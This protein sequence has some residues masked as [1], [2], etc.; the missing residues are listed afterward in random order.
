MRSLWLVCFSLLLALAAA[1]S[2]AYTP[3][4]GTWWTPNEP[5]TGL[6]I[7]VQDN[8]LV[9]AAYVYDPIG[10][11]TWYTAT[12]FLTGNARFDGQ[13]DA[14]VGGQC[15]GC[16]W[17][18]N[19]ERLG[20]GGPIRI[21]FNLTDPTKA[22]LT[23][24]GRTRPI[25]RF[26]FYLKRP[27]DGSRSIQLTKMLGEWQLVLD[28]SEINSTFPYAGDVI[29]FESIDVSQSP[30]FF[31]GCRVDDSLSGF[32]STFALNN[33]DAAG[34]YDSSTQEH[35]IV[36]SDTST[37]YLMY[38]GRVG[39]DHFRGEVSSYRKG[40]NP[41]TFYPARGFRSASRSFVDEGIGPSKAADVDAAPRQGLSDLFDFDQANA[42]PAAKRISKIEP[43]RLD[44]IRLQLEQ[45]LDAH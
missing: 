20:A 5:G 40:T 8:F 27:E 9:A 29:A 36:L 4:S 35:V 42:T 41:V 32:C 18:P 1:P 39:T 30:G 2:R 10:N 11:A 31:E 13:L 15:I 6:F 43:S 12:G 14:F 22:N 33:R 37:H 28:F 34:F 16:P 24:G 26:Q 44:A 3:E 21:D 25:E 17:R 7:E 45:R 23:W 19:S 38:V